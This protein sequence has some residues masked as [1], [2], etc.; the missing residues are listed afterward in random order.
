MIGTN[1]RRRSGP[2]SIMMA[3]TMVARAI[4][5]GSSLRILV[6]ISTRTSVQRKNITPIEV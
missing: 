6:F 4:S 1:K 2:G 5:S 3:Q